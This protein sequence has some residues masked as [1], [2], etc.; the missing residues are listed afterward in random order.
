MMI[1]FISKYDVIS[2]IAARADMRVSTKLVD[3]IFQDGTNPYEEFT[4]AQRTWLYDCF[5]DALETMPEDED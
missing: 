1:D 4:P 3:F 2:S 5:L